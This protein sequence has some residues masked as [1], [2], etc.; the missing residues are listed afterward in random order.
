MRF[1]EW[2]VANYL[3]G[4]YDVNG[5]SATFYSDDAAWEY[6][7]RVNLPPDY[8]FAGTMI[9][10]SGE[11]KVDSWLKRQRLWERKAK[12]EPWLDSHYPVCPECGR[13][14]L[15]GTDS[16][17]VAC[18]LGPLCKWT[19]RISGP[20]CGM[21]MQYNELYRALQCTNGYCRQRWRLYDPLRNYVENTS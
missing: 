5:K 2:T 6:L 11:V 15:E 3:I 9:D 18:L 13:K 14:C 19:G 10:V 16:G 1:I 17:D 21:P 12:L 4:T 20:V 7:V 8:N